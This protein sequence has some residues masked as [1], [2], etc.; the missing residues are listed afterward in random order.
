MTPSSGTFHGDPIARLERPFRELVEW[1]RMGLCQTLAAAMPRLDI[2]MLAVAALLTLISGCDLAGDDQPP[3]PSSKPHSP[4]LETSIRGDR[5]NQQKVVTVEPNRHDVATGAGNGT[6]SQPI[7]PAQRIETPEPAAP[8]NAGSTESAINFFN[9]D[10]KRGFDA[11]TSEVAG[12][13]A[14]KDARRLDS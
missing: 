10:A 4:P 3:P 1:S 5:A 8:A 6:A 14:Q 11:I 13:Q 12:A 2:R 9:G 7:K